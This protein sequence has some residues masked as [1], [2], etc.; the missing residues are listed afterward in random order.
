[1]EYGNEY[2]SQDA[3]RDMDC[4]EH[5]NTEYVAESTSLLDTIRTWGTKE[6]LAFRAQ[7]DAAGVSHMGASSA[8]A[9]SKKVA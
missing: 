3:E 4:R 7:M 5:A 1:M 9:Q 6:R 8:I 2:T